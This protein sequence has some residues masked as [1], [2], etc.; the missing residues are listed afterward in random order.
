MAVHALSVLMVTTPSLQSE[1]PAQLPLLKIHCASGVAMRV[2]TVPRLY[3]SE[4]SMPQL[5]PTG[6]LV[7]V[8]FP[9]LVIMSVRVDAPGVA[10]AIGVTVTE[11]GV[12]GGVFVGSVQVDAEPERAGALNQKANGQFT[13]VP[14]PCTRGRTRQ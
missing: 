14:L 8:P 4:Q 13:G 11:G 2:T 1:S 10:V 7:T 6:R 12:T 9:T 5:M 3:C